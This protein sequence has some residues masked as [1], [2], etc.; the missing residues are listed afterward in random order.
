M[1]TTPCPICGQEI[2]GLGS[3]A[4]YAPFCSERCRIIDLGRWLGD[5]YRIPSDPD[6]SASAVDGEED[7]LP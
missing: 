4:A 3:E 1:N 7:E 2:P 6:S 5:S